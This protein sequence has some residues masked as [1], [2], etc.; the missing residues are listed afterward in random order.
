[1]MMVAP[2]VVRVT[3]LFVSTRPLVVFLT[4]IGLAR[5][6]SDAEMVVCTTLPCMG[7]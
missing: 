7:N 3:T 1:M 5:S 6:V 4:M 2:G